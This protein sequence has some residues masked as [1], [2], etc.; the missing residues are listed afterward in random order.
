[1]Y[2][3]RTVFSQTMDFLPR[4]SVRRCV[5]RYG[6]NSRIRSCTCYEQFLCMA[7]AQLTYRDSLRDTVLCLRALQKKLHHGGIQSQVL[8]STL[9]DANENRDW[10]IF[11]DRLY[12]MHQGSSFIVLRAKRNTRLRRLYS[13][14]VDKA[15]G[16][17]CDQTVM[18]KRLGL[19]QSLYTILQV[20]SIAL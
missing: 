19:D 17:L 15:C 7:F 5:Q 9:A 14:E 4:K 20:I 11:S 3:G 16:V 6:G 1:M 13:A 18:K 10:R 2:E 12:P 8:R